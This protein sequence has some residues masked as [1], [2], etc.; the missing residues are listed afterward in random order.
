MAEI[1]PYFLRL[2]FSINF[3]CQTDPI[4]IIQYN[5]FLIQTPENTVT[6]IISQTFKLK[7]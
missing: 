2:F 3:L 1:D 6:E 7:N 4:I 5:T